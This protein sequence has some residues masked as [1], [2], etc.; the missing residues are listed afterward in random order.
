M[1]ILTKQI[2]LYV[3]LVINQSNIRSKIYFTPG[4]ILHR[5]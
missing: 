4:N 5:H 3:L 1:K 2:Q